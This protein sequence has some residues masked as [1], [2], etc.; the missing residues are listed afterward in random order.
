MSFG[1]FLDPNKDWVDTVHFPEIH[2]LYPPQAGFYRITGKVIE[3]FG[4]YSIEVRRMEKAGIRGKGDRAN[5]H[6]EQGL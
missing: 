4:V 3:E 1:T 5:G 2:A 6:P